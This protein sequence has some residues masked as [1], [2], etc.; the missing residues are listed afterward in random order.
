[1]PTGAPNLCSC[2][3]H[4]PM[5]ASFAFGLHGATSAVSQKRSLAAVSNDADVSG[6]GRSYHGSRWRSGTPRLLAALAGVPAAFDQLSITG[7]RAIS[8]CP[9]RGLVLTARSISLGL[10][11]F[12]RSMPLGQDECV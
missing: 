4:W 2:A 5:V 8:E 7:A 3:Y 9:P 12:R 10:R 6:E 1:M 11:Q